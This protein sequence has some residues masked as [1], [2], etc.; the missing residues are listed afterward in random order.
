[1]TRT[2]P[3]RVPPLPGEAIDSWLE[4]TAHRYGVPFGDV[5]EAC[6][7]P[8]RNPPK[9]RLRMSEA[10][11]EGVATATGIDA[12]TAADLTL[13]RFDGTA[14]QTEAA[15]RTLTTFP[16]GYRAW[17]RF[18][19]LCLAETGGRWQLSWRLGWSFACV[20]HRCILADTCPAC[21][22][23][24]RRRSG[25][26]SLVPVPGKCSSATSRSDAC[27]CD[28][29][30]AETSVLPS[31]D[32]IVVAQ[33]RVLS[34][35]HNNRTDLAVYRQHQA[36]AKEGLRDLKAL[37]ARYLACADRNGLH[38]VLKST[39]Q[40]NLAHLADA[41]P[42]RWPHTTN[43]SHLITPAVAV[44]MAIATEWAVSILDETTLERAADRARAVV[45]AAEGKVRLK[46]E[47]ELSRESPLMNG[48]L[49][50]AH[51]RTLSALT[52]LRYRASAPDPMLPS[53]I[54]DRLHRLLTRV[55]AS[56]WPAWSV[57][58]V[59]PG[60]PSFARAREALAAMLLLVGT[61][62]PMNSIIADCGLMNGPRA[63]SDCLRTFSRNPQW[64]AVSTA[65]IRLSDY[66]NRVKPPIDYR[67]RRSL[68]YSD[69]L[70]GARW[71]QVCR[72]TGHLD[73]PLGR[74]G[75]AA[76]A[77]LFERISA[78]EARDWSSPLST[79]QIRAQRD[80]I[81]RF[82]LLL[83]SRVAERLM[84]EA[85]RF[86]D[87]QGVVEPVSWCP[88]L[89]LIADLDLLGP[90]LRS[91]DAG[92]LRRCS[93]RPFTSVRTL[94][95]DFNLSCYAVRYLLSN[96]PA[97]LSD[98]RTDPTSTSHRWGRP[99]VLEQASTGE[100][101]ELYENQGRT[102]I[103]IARTFRVSS[104]FVAKAA[105][106]AHISKHQ[107]PL[108]AIDPQWVHEQ[109]HVKRRTL[110]DI[111]TEIGIS[112]TTLW[113]WRRNHEPCSIG[114]RG[115]PVTPHA[116]IGTRLQH[117]VTALFESPEGRSLLWT[118]EELVRYPN[119]T[120]AA[121][122][123]GITPFVVGAR[124]RKL[125][126]QLGAPLIHR[127]HCNLPLCPTAQGRQALVLISGLRLA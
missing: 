100:L 95:K 64:D 98:A 46:L 78:A 28:F 35:V 110:R 117:Q 10:E 73:S 127:A 77:Y 108:S 26:Y 57:R 93:L 94:A 65:L 118:F 79:E 67:R 82:P 89:E 13:S 32:S 121:N 54:D 113:N 107:S 40:D 51:N 114:K 30:E 49:I 16:F 83:S 29:T 48:V 17:S 60:I 120:A 116:C 105:A 111:A 47:V 58:L 59:S 71:K 125:E 15:T 88:P 115:T 24:Q 72:D 81:L 97:D 109:H 66:L 22:R 103:D 39:G 21:R 53:P 36:S 52:R 63:V 7:L 5:V 69:L 2:L 126:S 84:D 86:L 23:W 31:A 85:R 19:P 76:R 123:I 42:T 101:R 27:S 119:Y 112:E 124:V 33:Q 80:S 75:V 102:L 99:R 1:M 122:G 20:H 3:L 61:A 14:P 91:I 74:M 70:T 6:G 43:T 12:E 104:G 18:C 96:T 9:W 11:C 55:P 68:D 25:A 87:R 106:Q 90:D 62:E 37:I 44:H 4:Y 38:W 92:E 8:R 45:V 34:I 41:A 50:K 56:L